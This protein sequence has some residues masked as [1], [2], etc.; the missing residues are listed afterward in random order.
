[1]HERRIGHRIERHTSIGSTN[2][3]ARELLGLPDGDGSVVVAEEQT[4]GRGRRGR[5]WESPPGRNVLMS[6]ALVRDLP[7]AQSWRIGLATALAVA[8]ACE[9]VAPISLK[10]P[11][12][13]VATSDGRKL[14]GLLIETMAEGDRL[15]SAVLGV[16]INVNWRRAEMPADLRDRA[17]SLCDLAGAPVDREAL[18]QRLLDGLEAEFAAIE[19]GQSPLERYRARCSTLGSAVR[20]ETAEGLVQGHALDLDASAALVVEDGEGRRHVITGGEVTRVRPAVPA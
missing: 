6:V 9:D 20:V 11:N 17:T 5:S 18:L 12:D 14:G 3:R 13:V 7:A 10:W 16:G 19:A 15:R 2:D 4:S 1:M 8:D